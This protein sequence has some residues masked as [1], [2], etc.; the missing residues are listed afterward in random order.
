V[1]P[2]MLSL[3]IAGGVDEVIERCRGLI[4]A[5]AGHISFGPPLGPDPMRAVV[6]LGREVLPALG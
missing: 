3:G 6:A 2:R 4:A 1:T 5:G